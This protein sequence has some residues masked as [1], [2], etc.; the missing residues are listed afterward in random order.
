[1][2]IVDDRVE[3]R[4]VLVAEPDQG[5]QE[6]PGVPWIDARSF[7]ASM[8]DA[9]DRRAILFPP[10]GH[11]LRIVGCRL[12]AAVVALAA[13]CAQRGDQLPSPNSQPLENAGWSVAIS[14]DRLIVGVARNDS[15]Q[16][17]GGAARIYA[18]DG[19][20]W[21]LE[22]TLTPGVPVHNANFGWS[23][24]IDGDRAIVGAFTDVTSSVITGAA[25]IFE[26]SNSGWAEVARLVPAPLVQE[27]GFGATVSI[28]G[29]RAVVGAPLAP[30]PTFTGPGLA[31]VFQREN[32]AWVQ[33]SMLTANDA[34]DFD[35]FGTSVSIN[36]DRMVIGAMR[37]D[38]LGNGSGA[39]YVLR[40]EASHWVEEAKLL[41]SDG[42]E[43]DRFGRAVA[44]SGNTIVVGAHE[45]DDDGEA[46]GAA[47]VFESDGSG[48]WSQTAKLVAFD[49]T[50]E[51]EYGR[52]VGV[53]EDVAIVGAWLGYVA[54]IRSGAAY[55]Y[56]RTSGNWMLSF[57]LI[58]D[59][60]E[61]GDGLGFSV[62]V[63]GD[64]V[65]AGAVNDDTPAG[66]DAGSAYA[67]CGITIPDPGFEFDVICCIQPP[68]P[69]GPVI[70]TTRVTNRRDEPLV[71][72]T[73][74]D[75]LPPDGASQR[76]TEPESIV[77]GPNETIERRLIAAIG[78]G[79]GSYRLIVSFTTPD[80]VRSIT[81]T[82]QR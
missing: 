79:A 5:G 21:Q 36:G 59:D 26:R 18:R 41:P 58:P 66:T 4:N 34:I 53:D 50:A 68:D 42:A 12:G 46:S 37:D 61:Y 9:Q 15:L 54:D 11:L 44:I 62:D 55:V 30:P 49:A 74:A 69:I 6:L 17:N 72:R 28:S 64:C 70:Y 48:N 29:D 33:D 77:V 35:E 40:R 38:D 43:F 73:W 71:T 60:P 65:V 27:S 13:A 82:F 75:L 31:Y 39:A 51:A 24:D 22:A 80:G 67:R 16:P 45:D 32:S 78:A 57:K 47:Y 52:A 19:D 63:S 2:C 23:V 8:V 14:G 1:V 25:Y 76:V 56:R 3:L 20:A 81:T 10:S 7:Q